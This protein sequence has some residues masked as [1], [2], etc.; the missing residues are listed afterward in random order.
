MSG[1]MVTAF[2]GLLGASAEPLGAEDQLC[3]REWLREVME[4]GGKKEWNSL[5]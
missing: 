4:T 1:H 3:G 5:G 2:Q